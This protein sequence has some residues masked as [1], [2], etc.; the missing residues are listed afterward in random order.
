MK[1]YSHLIKFQIGIK[2]LAEQKLALLVNFCLCDGYITM[3]F[4]K[5]ISMV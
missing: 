1:T 5:C 2:L 4:E 3:L